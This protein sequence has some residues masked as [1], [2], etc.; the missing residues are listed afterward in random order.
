LKI[1][2]C[3]TMARD[4]LLFWLPETVEFHLSFNHLLRNVGSSQ[5]QRASMGDTLWIVTLTEGFELGLAGRLLV[6]DV[7]PK[8]FAELLLETTDLWDSEFHALAEVGTA[9]RMRGVGL[10][11][12]AEELRFVDGQ[13]DRFISHNGRINPDQLKGMRELDS[14]SAQ[15]MKQIWLAAV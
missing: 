4:F 6:G 10:G 12:D 15:L 8:M 13:P 1:G 9:E 11:F 7:V 2:E 14:H 3:K 5:I